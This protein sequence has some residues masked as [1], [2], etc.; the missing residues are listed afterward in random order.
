MIRLFYQAVWIS[1]V[2]LLT[3]ASARAAVISENFSTTPQSGGWLVVGNTNLFHW[4]STNQNLEVTWNSTQTN[5]YFYRPLTNILNRSDDFG[6]AFD[7]RLQDVASATT[8]GKPYD[9]PLAL[10]F[11]NF[12]NAT[13]PKFS[14]GAGFN[15]TYGPK[16]LVEFN[17]FPPFSIYLPTIAE[18]IICTN[19]NSWFYNHD[20]LQEMTTGD[21]FH[22]AMNFVGT[23]RTLTTTVTRNGTAYGAPQMITVPATNDFRV[24]AF[25]ISSYSDQNASGSILAHGTIDNVVITVPPPPVQNLRGVITNGQWRV[26][27]TSRTNWNYTLQRSQSLS[28]WTDTSGTING[29][30]A[31]ISLTDTNSALPSSNFYRVK[32][33][34]SN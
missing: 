34:R 15:A 31:Q 26:D 30:G 4:N 20:N 32:A 2:G 14:R 10:G 6:V 12:T 16:N 22:V 8:P 23:T 25:S 28:Q 17:Y 11:L 13:D 1:I 27:F 3:A 33:L 29:T 7:L 5:S 9:F 19:N 24:D 21:L 18:S